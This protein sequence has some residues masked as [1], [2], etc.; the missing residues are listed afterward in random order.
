MVSIYPCVD[1]LENQM[2]HAEMAHLYC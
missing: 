1:Q 2:I